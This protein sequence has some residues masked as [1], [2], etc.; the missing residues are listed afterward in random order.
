[1]FSLCLVGLVVESATSEQDV[2]GSTPGS[3][4]VPGLDLCPVFSNRL[5]P[6]LGLKKT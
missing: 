1:M 6:F 2:L 5:A 3:G 4:N